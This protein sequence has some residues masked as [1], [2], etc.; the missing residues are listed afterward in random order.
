MDPA[1]KGKTRSSE[2]SKKKYDLLMKKY[3]IRIQLLK[4]QKNTIIINLY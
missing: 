4:R 1:K 2:K 3:Q